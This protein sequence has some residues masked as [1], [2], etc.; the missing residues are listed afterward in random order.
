[1]NSFFEKL[2]PAPVGGGFRRDDDWVWCGSVVEGYDGRFHM[3]ASMWT[4]D[5]GFSPNWLTNSRVVR[6]VADRPEGP[7]EYAGEVLPPRGRDHWDGMMTHNPTIHWHDGTYLLYYTGTTYDGDMP[8]A[9]NP[10]VSAEMRYQ[11]RANQRIGLA[12]AKSPEGPWLR[13]SAPILEPRPG[14]WDAHLTTNPAPVVHDDGSVMLYYKSTGH[15]KDVLQYGGAAAQHW[16]GPYDRLSNEPIF[17]FDDPKATY[18]DAFV[19]YDS[20][21]YQMIFNDLGGTITGEHHGG[22]HATSDDGIHWTISKEPKAY[23]RTIRWDDGTTTTR[24]HFERPQLLIQDG[25]PTHLFAATT[26]DDQPFWKS[27]HTY[28][29]VVPLK[30]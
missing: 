9:A 2:L 24:G 15:D 27:A 1:M 21:C 29:M 26:I 17:S 11:A 8:D 4:K 20:W 23:S 16:T 28:N 13:R 7:Y 12:T 19:W 30:H 22:A 10:A 6:A 3:F 18:E 5:V 14:K 25:V